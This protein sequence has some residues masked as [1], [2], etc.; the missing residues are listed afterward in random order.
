MG[1]DEPQ[2]LE[3][4]WGRKK[5]IEDARCI[6][7]MDEILMTIVRKC[8][9]TLDPPYSWALPSVISCEAKTPSF[10]VVCHCDLGLVT[11]SC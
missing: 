9:R 2:V 7:R 3:A 11:R 5:E 4:M 10:F 8:Q 6:S 1:E